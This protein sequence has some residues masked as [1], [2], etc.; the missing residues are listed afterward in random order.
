[1]VKIL[2]LPIILFIIFGF[3][4]ADMVE[5][6]SFFEEDITDDIFTRELI[7]IDLSLNVSLSAQIS[8]TISLLNDN[9][10]PAAPN[11]TPTST[12]APL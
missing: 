7:N 10:S 9:G 3:T 2:F 5:P 1:M 11:P 6:K 8:G 4:F 12:T